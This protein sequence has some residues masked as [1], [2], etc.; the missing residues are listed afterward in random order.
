LDQGKVAAVPKR[1]PAQTYALVF[2]LGLLAAGILGLT[3]VLDLSTWHNLLHVVSG[4]AGLMAVR[5]YPR[6]RLYALVF[7]AVY[8]LAAAFGLGGGEGA[9]LHALVGAT[10]LG[11]GLATPGTPAPTTA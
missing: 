7:G 1:T 2:G 3:G 9:V 11:A 10:G 5:S 4:V 8:V 6:A